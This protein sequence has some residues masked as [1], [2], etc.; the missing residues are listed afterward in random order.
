MNAGKRG[1]GT[2]GAAASASE[3]GGGGGRSGAASHTGG[4]EVIIVGEEIVEYFPFDVAGGA[5]AGSCGGGGRLK[6]PNVRC[7]ER[8]IKGNFEISDNGKIC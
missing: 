5:E 8:Y 6:Q 4:V 7:A 3:V 1:G 2:P